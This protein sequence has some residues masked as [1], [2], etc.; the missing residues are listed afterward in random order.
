MK[1]PRENLGIKLPR[2]ESWQ[3]IFGYDIQSLR[4]KM[5]NKQV[6]LYQTKSLLYSKRNDQGCKKIICGIGKIF[7]S[8]IPDKELL[9]RIYKE[10]TELNS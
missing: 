10:L 7:T 6:G 2:H 1:L 8:H 5:K 4:D 9:Y 3:Y